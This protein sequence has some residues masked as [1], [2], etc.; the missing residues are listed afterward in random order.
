[1]ASRRGAAASDFSTRIRAGRPHEGMKHLLGSSWQRLGL[2]IAL[3]SGIGL[4]FMVGSHRPLVHAEG[5]GDC[6]EEGECTF[7]KPNVMLI[8]DY[9]TSMNNVWDLDNDLTRWESAVQ[10]IEYAFQA[11]S[12]LSQNTHVALMRFGHDPSPEA[13]TPI[14]ADSSG[15]VDGQKLDVPWYDA[16]DNSW[17]ECNGPAIAAALTAAG[18][19]LG[20]DLVGIGAWTKGAMDHAKIVIDQ[21]IADHP[22]DDGERPYL[23]VVVTDGAWNGQ[24]GTGSPEDQN[25]AITAANLYDDDGV[26][27]HVIALAGDAEAKLAADQLA[28]AGGTAAAIEADTPA[29][30]EQGLAELV[31][32]IID[33]V[34]SPNC[35]GGVPRIMVLLD[36]SSSML[37]V[38]GGTMA[39]EPGL[40]GWDQ[41]R[42]ALAG[43]VSLFDV[44]VGGGV[45][46]VR[47]AFHFG[48]AV[49][50]HGVPAPGEQKILIDYGPCVHDNF[51]WALD[52]Q[53]SCTMPGCDDPW[54]GPPITWT[55]ADGQQD[56][57]G[58]NLPTTS[59]MPQCS[60]DTLY[61]QGSGTYT[62]LGLQAVR[63]HQAAYLAAAQLPNAPFPADEQTLFVNILI[64]DGRYD[65]YSTDAQVQTELEQMFAVGITTHVIGYGDGVDTP[66]A[67]AQLQTMADWGSGG[68]LDYHDA[69]NQFLLEAALAEIVDG[70]SFDPCCVVSDCAT[71]PE[72]RP[73]EPCPI[74]VDTGNGEEPDPV[75]SDETDTTESTTD[76]STTDESTTDESTTDETTT[77]ETAGE[78][79][80]ETTGDS[81]GEE[82]TT[83]GTSDDEIGDDSTS[84]PGSEG[85]DQ[86][87][88][89][90]C[91][92]ARSEGSP[93]GSLLLLGLAGLIRRRRPR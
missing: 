43:D 61:C 20:G 47:D 17:H 73:G 11:N 74:D 85:P 76:E 88:D 62:H 13:G 56:P 37:N 12:F 92:N 21:A 81:S 44:E 4:A 57:P 58:F 49:F 71:C 79:T 23:L 15:I 90:N 50:G 53:S 83:T 22:E 89:C 84:D 66:A 16:Q 48:L 6:P 7:K 78:T 54:A 86:A 75:P 77:D 24:D 52:P 9:S 39:G 32:E 45:A 70:V 68:L 46:T 59:H 38:N 3:L 51:A 87:G 55:F 10:S 64:T 42:E 82:T 36:A 8:V 63:T 65:F 29:L 72:P 34:V 67:I 5:G 91:A 35:A 93:L 26:R 30:L 60:G 2:Q 19:P 14:P 25:P 31:Q 80:D 33:G 18:D 40:T 1:V 41:A 27:T 69:N 28:S